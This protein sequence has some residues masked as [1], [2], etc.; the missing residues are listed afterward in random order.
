MA[1]SMNS[2]QVLH[3]SETSIKKKTRH[4]KKKSVIYF[5]CPLS[6]TKYAEK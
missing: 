1:K 2:E 6:L 5:S 4:N 3:N